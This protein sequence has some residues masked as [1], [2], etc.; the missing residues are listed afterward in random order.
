MLPPRILVKIRISHVFFLYL[1]IAVIASIQSYLGSLHPSGLGEKVYH[2]YNNYI[3]FK[4]SFFHL[5]QGKDLYISYPD[6]QWDLYKYSPTF[7]L[8]FGFFSFLPDF[9][10]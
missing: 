6:E 7:S 8:F 10:G 5:I 9:I 3:L 2:G 4:N 1:A